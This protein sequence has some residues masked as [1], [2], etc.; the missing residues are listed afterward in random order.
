MRSTLLVILIA[1]WTQGF[2]QIFDTT[3][4]K[5]ELSSFI[6]IGSAKSLN[7]SRKTEDTTLDF[8]HSLYGD[9][10]NSP[11]FV[12]LGRIVSASKSLE[13]TLPNTSTFQLGPRLFANYFYHPDSTKY[14]RSPTARTR[15]KYSQG[16]GNLLYLNAQHSQNIASNWSFGLDY[17]RNKSHNLYFNNF[18]LFDQERMT[19]LFSTR[20]YTHFNTTNH[21]YEVFANFVNSKN[22]LRESFSIANS[23]G[24]DTLSGRAKTYSGQAFLSDANNVFINRDFSVYQFYRPGDRTIRINDTTL[25][26]DTTT[27]SIA[28]QWFH[29]LRYSRNINEFTD[30]DYNEAVFPARLYTLETADSVFHSVLHNSIGQIRKGNRFTSSYWIQHES[31]KVSQ[32]NAH[33]SRFQNIQLGG[34]LSSR[35]SNSRLFVEGKYN[36]LGYYSGDYALNVSHRVSFNETGLKTNVNVI[37]HR[38]DYNDQFFGSNYYYWNQPLSKTDILEASAVFF[39]R[40]TG[41]QIGGTYRQVTNFV[42][43]DTSG[44]PRQ[45][46]EAINYFKAF[47]ANHFRFGSNWHMEQRLCFQSASNK[48]MAIPDITYKTRIYKEGFLF[49]KNMWARIGL[50]VAYFSSFE[51]IGY[52]PVIRQF[53]LSNQTIGGYPVVDLFLNTRVNSM[54]LFAS[55]NHLTQGFFNNDSFSAAA[56]P[57]VGRAFRFGVDWRLFE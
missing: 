30:N 31:V 20:A 28:S 8:S 35:T 55:V 27:T 24:F 50:D 10:V 12:H 2:G 34:N 38:P 51:G 53:T 22:T 25:V 47:L 48:V 3:E 23:E 46:T 15:L 54:L 19:N 43:L 37:K 5:R 40:K 44:L 11:M 45:H 36:P 26:A 42:Y 7:F 57:L 4:Y 21:K 16:T 33:Q 9:D 56:Y 41:L 14:F 29:H 32:L 17:I 6:E 1:L 49:K 39:T 18:P 52:N 13:P